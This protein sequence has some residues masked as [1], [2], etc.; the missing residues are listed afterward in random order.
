M[1]ADTQ[2]E[3]PPPDG[4]TPGV[5]QSPS[6][7]KAFAAR[8]RLV[9]A[10]IA[11]MIGIQGL[12]GFLS[13]DNDA[14]LILAFAYVPASFARLVDPGAVAVAATQLVRQDVATA[15]DVVL[16]LGVGGFRWWTPLTYALLHGGWTHVLVNSVWLA[17]FGSAV[18]RR[19][20][21]VRFLMFFAITAIGGAVA[22]SMTHFLQFAPLVGASAAISGAMAG[23]ARFAFAPGAPLGVAAQRGSLL[24]YQGPLVSLRHLL[25][26]PRA[27]TFLVAWFA[28]NFIFGALATPIGVADASIAWEA[29]IGGFLT[30]LLLFRAFDPVHPSRPSPPASQAARPIA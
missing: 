7:D 21:A 27:M 4:V 18:A 22:H 9:L 28:A 8:G 13:P 1:S 15:D 2:S 29:H 16:L 14:R 30:G 26:E 6:S 23:A 12:R 24:A 11:L 3:S 25:R 19:L 5:G 17:A 20:G 10:L